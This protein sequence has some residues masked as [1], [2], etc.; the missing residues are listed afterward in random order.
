MARTNRPDEVYHVPTLNF[1]FAVGSIILLITCVWM[2]EAD[3]NRPWKQYQREFREYEITRLS[4]GKALAEAKLD[5][6]DLKAKLAAA[7]QSLADAE[8]LVSGKRDE[9][10]RLN[11]ELND[12]SK[13]FYVAKQNYNFKKADLGSARYNTEHLFKLHP[14]DREQGQA[15]YNAV[16]EEVAKLETAYLDVK[17]QVEDV[18]RQRDQL[19]AERNKAEGA[20]AGLTAEVTT[21][22]KAL[23]KIEHNFFNDVIRDAPVI[24][25]VR[26]T[27]KI[28]QIVLP[29]LRD[30]YNFATVQKEDR[31]GTCHLGI[32]KKDYATRSDNVRFVD[33]ATRATMEAGLWES[34]HENITASAPAE[35]LE[36]I[37][38]DFDENF[39][40]DPEASL[41]A[42]ADEN[43]EDWDGLA[44]AVWAGTEEAR[45]DLRRN[46][47]V[48]GAHP[49]LDLYLSSMSP[50][51]MD[52]V[53]CTSCHE[54]RGHAVD[55]QR[56]Y[57]T[58]QN[59]VQAKEW[60]EK[61]HWHEAHYWDHVQLPV[62]RVTASCAKC[63]DED[64]TV[65]QADAYN[66]GKRLVQEAGCP[67]C[68]QMGGITPN[69]RK[70]GPDLRK[71]A[72]KVPDQ[73][74]AYEWIW[75][76][77]SFRPDTK[78]PH[79]FEQTNNSKEAN[80][81]YYQRTRQEVRGVVTYLYGL[82]DDY[83]LEPM[84]ARGNT[85]RGE[86]LF[87]EV[88][89]LGCHSQSEEGK[90]VN[91]HG[92][93]LSGIG[94]KLS[95]EFIYS[96]IRDPKRYFAESHMP[97]MRLTP[98]E[99]A[100]IAAY[101]A[102]DKKEGWATPEM[103]ARDRALQETLLRD[104]MSGSMRRD[105][106]T[107]K[108]EAMS[109][110]EREFELGRR[111]LIKYGCT[112]CHTVKG[113]EDASP[114]GAELTT[115]ASKFKTQLDFG[116]FT[117]ND[118]EHNHI[119]WL[120]H[121]LANPR[122]YDK[123]KETTKTFGELLKMPK[124]NFTPDEIDK[125]TTFILSRSKRHIAPSLWPEQ[126]PERDAIQ[127][128]MWIVEQYNCKGCH[129]FDGEGGDFAQYW[130]LNNSTGE[131]EF[132]ASAASP[133]FD[134]L[135]DIEGPVRGHVPPVLLDQGNKTEP[136]WLF[137]FFANPTMLRP[138]LKMRMPSFD[139]SDD[140]AN[141]LIK[142]F[143]GIE[144]HGVGEISS[145]EPDPALALIGQRLFE[146]GKCVRC[147]MFTDRDVPQNAIPAG[148]VAPNLKLAG[149]RLQHTWTPRWMADPQSIMPGANMPNYF[150]L[151]AH[152]TALD[153]DGT[154]LGD[155]ME[156]GM[157][158][159]RDYLELSGRSY[160]PTAPMV[161]R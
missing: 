74:F 17:D 85:H 121:K 37:L 126:T 42:W 114:I 136:A 40:Q 35:D 89:C 149:Q 5:E 72:S 45:E 112:G 31:C 23:T 25:F 76:P 147:H 2:I 137:D 100:D 109:D 46:T 71:Y 12:L 54:G 28:N 9:I 47:V 141:A 20:I 49:N 131:A 62:G 80:P 66:E 7:T 101:L 56:A 120:G 132:H 92:P 117:K 60:E 26:P 84:S 119:A 113:M 64:V 146:N 130:S 134:Y 68:H 160:R 81:D 79:F 129:Y 88:G 57:H 138:K 97:S 128:G 104:A 34:V 22:S 105:A 102:A 118:M 75:N 50:H 91:S 13:V 83:E 111:T 155:D 152:Y 90:T 69:T 65:G 145:Y 158:A 29:E 103:P 18:E 140:E 150:D 144:G 51:P 27:I 122:V 153:P 135:E 70:V 99:A 125:V 14:E 3:Y 87:N 48:Y 53:G 59:E 33:A 94:S 24:D 115:W 161:R 151:E 159:L 142:M 61:Y 108:L 73:N 116:N 156:K 98:Q 110:H 123:D 148:V 143:A 38:A 96:W 82:Q 133:G 44:D 77:K 16:V 1:W 30:D 19:L 39:M 78:M 63:H 157:K 154:M 93:D 6:G 127:E 58:P 107:A 106:L 11:A 10:T 95:A 41:K 67:G 36:D 4:K 124:F 32:D 52:V 139:F 8:K 43:L 21:F 86:T 15:E 55:F